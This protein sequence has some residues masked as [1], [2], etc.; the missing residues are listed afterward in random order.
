MA[1]H[2]S[3]WFPCTKEIQRVF[4][5]DGSTKPKSISNSK[6]LYNYIHLM[7]SF[8]IHNKNIYKYE[9]S[10]LYDWVDTLKKNKSSWRESSKQTNFAFFFKVVPAP[11]EGGP[12]MYGSLSWATLPTFESQL[13]DGGWP[14]KKG[15][16]WR[17]QKNT[18]SNGIFH[19]NQHLLY[20]V[21]LKLWWI[22]LPKGIQIYG[23]WSWIWP[24]YLVEEHISKWQSVD[25]ETWIYQIASDVIFSYRFCHL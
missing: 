11:Y 7:N 15:H 1:I 13:F 9:K 2:D 16:P 21:F 25:S 10:Y 14:A 18:Q 19:K 6:N 12:S 24:C 8:S 20:S 23:C 4:S 5:Q 22:L 17:M 3:I